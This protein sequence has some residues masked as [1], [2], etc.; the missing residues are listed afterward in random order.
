MASSVSDSSD[1]SDLFTTSDISSGQSS[2]Y[3]PDNND[4]PDTEYDKPGI[5]IRGDSVHTKALDNSSEYSPPIESSSPLQDLVMSIIDENPLLPE[6]DAEM[7]DRLDSLVTVISD[8]LD[9]A[10]QL[11]V[12][13]SNEIHTLQNWLEQLSANIHRPD[14]IYPSIDQFNEPNLPHTSTLT[15]EDP[16]PEVITSEPFL[17]PSLQPS[18]PLSESASVQPSWPATLQ[19]TGGWL[20]SNLASA[21]MGLLRKD[22][23]EIASTN[24]YT[25]PS[26][27]TPLSTTKENGAIAPH[28]WNPTGVYVPLEP[29]VS[30]LEGPQPSAIVDFDARTIRSTSGSSSQNGTVHFE[31]AFEEP[32][33]MVPEKEAPITCDNKKELI[34][35]INVLASPSKENPGSTTQCASTPFSSNDQAAPLN[36]SS[37]SASEKL[38][39]VELGNESAGCHEATTTVSSSVNDIRNPILDVL[40]TDIKE[41]DTLQPMSHTTEDTSPYAQLATQLSQLVFEPKDGKSRKERHIR[42]INQLWDAASRLAKQ[43]C[44]Q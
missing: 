12:S 24:T 43:E 14:S 15:L 1:M 39:E 33:L 21:G 27:L 35:L 6:Y 16:D 26:S 41:A 37:P 11:P 29:S 2:L 18:P 42:V 31:T 36:S 10:R 5:R 20:L 17:Y 9:P 7:M 38:T 44:Q 40:A 8:N 30:S 23:P 22:S 34:H 3:S 25:P 19:Q 28:F 13:E 32:V 4:G